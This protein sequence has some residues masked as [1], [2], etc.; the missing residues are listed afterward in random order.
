MAAD[1]QCADVNNRKILADLKKPKLFSEVVRDYL[2]TASGAFRFTQLLQRITAL[3]AHILE[4]VGSKMAE[5]AQSLSGKFGTTCAMLGI[6]RL[7]DAT[8][9]S[10]EAVVK[11]LNPP[12][13]I[14][15]HIRRNTAESVRDVADGIST[16]GY[17]GAVLLANTMMKLTGDFFGL[18][19]DLTDMGLSGQDLILSHDHLKKLEQID[20]TKTDVKDRLTENWRLSLLKVIKTS[21]A[22]LS[23][24]LGFMALVVGGPIL[25]VAAMIVLGLFCTVSAMST[26]FYEKAIMKYPTIDFFKQ[27][28]P[29]V[30]A[31]G[32]PAY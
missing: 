18:F 28:N 3:A 16:W 32:L 27:R 11:W 14:D 19:A 24:T 23:G 7:Y 30:L 17:A 10:K 13:S 4:R 9:K 25:P 20:P 8:L 21:L 15:D 2:G 12:S 5:A 22:I 26:Y 31:E 29:V 6:P 1:V